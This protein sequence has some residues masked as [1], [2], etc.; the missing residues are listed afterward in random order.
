[1]Q[2]FLPPLSLPHNYFEAFI[3]AIT[4]VVSDAMMEEMAIHSPVPN[5]RLIV[6]SFAGT[7]T[8]D[9]GVTSGYDLKN[10]N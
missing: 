7:N 8:S 3:R 10:R 6:F 5:A 2:F 9:L 1:L 4:I